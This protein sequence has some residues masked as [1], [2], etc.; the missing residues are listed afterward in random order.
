MSDFLIDE[1]RL[2]MTINRFIVI[3]DQLRKASFTVSLTV[4]RFKMDNF[5]LT[6]GECIQCSLSSRNWNRLSQPVVDTRWSRCLE[7]H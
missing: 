2:Q 3:F 7:S 5:D 4:R 6:P 1:L